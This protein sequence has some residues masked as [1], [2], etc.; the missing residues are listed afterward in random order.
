[1]ARAVALPSTGSAGTCDTRWSP[2]DQIGHAA[3]GCNFGGVPGRV[4]GLDVEVVD[5]DVAAFEAV[6]QAFGRALNAAGGCVEGFAVG[7]WGW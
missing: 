3:T 1:M 2:T 6:D 5:R 7:E 4:E